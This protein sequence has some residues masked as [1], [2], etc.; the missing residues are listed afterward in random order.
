M[1]NS[2]NIILYKDF[3]VSV[4]EIKNNAKILIPI[5]NRRKKIIN[6][7]KV[8]ISIQEQKSL[9]LNLPKNFRKKKKLCKIN[10]LKHE[11]KSIAEKIY[12]KL[13]SLEEKT[14]DFEERNFNLSDKYK[15]ILVFFIFLFFFSRFFIGNGF[16]GKSKRI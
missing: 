12:K 10:T 9:Y 7:S 11:M 13:D 1:K 15:K 5:I 6:Q 2:L 14:K 4:I 16:F 8:L 3:E